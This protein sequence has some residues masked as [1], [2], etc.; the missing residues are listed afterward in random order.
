MNSMVAQVHS[1]P[2]LVRESTV[3]FDEIIRNTLTHDLCLSMKR[4]F[5]TGCGDS[6]HAA[7]TAEL[8]LESIAGMPTEPMTAMQ[9]SHYG[10]AHMPDTGPGTNIVI[11]ISVSGEVARTVEALNLANIKGATTIGLTATPGSRVDT[12]SELTIFSTIMP[13]PDPPGTHTPG[14]RSYAANQ[15]ALFL[16]AIRI[17]EIRGAISMEKAAALR[18]ELLGLAD[19]AEATINNCD[20]LAQE[21]AQAWS[22]ADEFVFAGS[23]PNFG[24]ALFSAAKVLEA[25]GDPAL[26]Q[27]LEE[28]AHLQ[29]FARKVHTPTF[30]INTGARDVPRALE[31]VG[32][33]R[34]IGRRIVVIAPQGRESLMDKADYSLALGNGVRE[35]F[36]PLIAAIPGELF[37]A[38]RA[39]VIGEPFFRNFGGGRSIEGGGGVSSIRESL[40]LEDIPE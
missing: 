15:L 8:A 23:G 30:L 28:W 7:L 6:H 3:K 2:D 10:V 26:G 33:A 4:L 16:I 17:G 37:A 25:S 11:G 12:N 9:F 39:D 14:V 20:P 18:A 29:Y 1:L 21:I 35:T 34:A 32:A 38:Y 22:D 13:F 19:A 5:L 36:S 27:D 31:V 40:M 24:T